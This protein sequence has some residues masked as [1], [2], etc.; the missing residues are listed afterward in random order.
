MC[1]GTEDGAAGQAVH[2]HSIP[3]DER[4]RTASLADSVLPPLQASFPVGSG[5][6]PRPQ[7]QPREGLGLGGVPKKPTSVE[8]E[9][10]ADLALAVDQLR[11]ANMRIEILQVCLARMGSQ[12]IFEV[13]SR[14]GISTVP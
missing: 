5:A 1:G 12:G 6:R 2:S 3:Y 11:R 4:V 9:L 8:A 10:S 14:T 7:T 13:D